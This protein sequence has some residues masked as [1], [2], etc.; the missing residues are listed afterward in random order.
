[1]IQI[2]D[3]SFDQMTVIIAGAVIFIVLLFLILLIMVVRRA[4]QSAEAVNF[5]AGQVGRLTQDVS[6]LGQGCLLYTSPSPRDRT[7]ARMPSSA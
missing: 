6:A 4:G 1:M 2:G 3:Q 5:V 7:R